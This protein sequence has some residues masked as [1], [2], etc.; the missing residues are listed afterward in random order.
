M[1][2]TENV[3]TFDGNQLYCRIQCHGPG[4]G[5]NKVLLQPLNSFFN[6]S[7]ITI[8]NIKP[9]LSMNRKMTA[10]RSKWKNIKQR[11]KNQQQWGE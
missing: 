10:T 11:F 9:K 8:D 7:R 2:R 4:Y 6:P 5:M 3:T 1:C